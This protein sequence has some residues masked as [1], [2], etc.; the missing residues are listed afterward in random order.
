ML[1]VPQRA[2]FQV[3]GSQDSG[4]GTKL[5]FDL[6]EGKLRGSECEAILCRRVQ[7]AAAKSPGVFDEKE[8]FGRLAARFREKAID[9]PGIRADDTAGREVGIGERIFAAD[10]RI[11]EAIAIGGKE[12]REPLR[13]SGFKQQAQR[14]YRGYRGHA[15][16]VAKP[17][18]LDGR[19]IQAGV[20]KRRAPARQVVAYARNFIQAKAKDLEP[21]RQPV[22]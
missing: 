22:R 9:L 8:S 12:R 4:F 17:G 6:G 14:R 21:V 3:H 2:E 5:E 18:N 19:I 15:R 13:P 1:F 20:E 10:S 7:T 11:E 16:E